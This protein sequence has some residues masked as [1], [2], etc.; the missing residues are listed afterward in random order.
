MGNSSTPI[1]SVESARSHR[2]GATDAWIRSGL[3]D[4]ETRAFL[5][6]PRYSPSFAKILRVI[7]ITAMVIATVKAAWILVFH[8]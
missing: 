8:A 2:F 4:A 6:R 7:L 1:G 5:E 3:P